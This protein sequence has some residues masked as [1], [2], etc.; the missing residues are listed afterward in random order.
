MIYWFQVYNI[1]I[2]LYTLQNGG[3]VDLSNNLFRFLKGN[4]TFILILCLQCQWSKSWSSL[5]EA[6]GESSE[7]KWGF[8][9][10]TV[11]D[12]S[13]SFVGP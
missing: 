3:E 7:C 4:Q 12:G 11:L 1:M 5:V 6:H 8:H 9:T 13:D 2:Q 10:L